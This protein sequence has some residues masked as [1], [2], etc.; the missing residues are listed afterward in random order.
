[1]TR[2]T[3]QGRPPIAAVR[4]PQI[5]ITLRQDVIDRIDRAAAAANDSRSRW[6]ER[7]AE[8]ELGPKK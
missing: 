6:I 4:R 2:P 7:L 5:S 1:M 3:A 8:R